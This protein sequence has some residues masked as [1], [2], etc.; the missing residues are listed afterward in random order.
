MKMFIFSLALLFIIRLRFPPH[1]SVYSIIL[2][3]YDVEGLHAIRAFEKVDYKLEKVRA[4]ARF[5]ECCLQNNLS[6][7]FLQFKLY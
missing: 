2:D 1:K 3:R 4:D 6:P 5:L 7:K